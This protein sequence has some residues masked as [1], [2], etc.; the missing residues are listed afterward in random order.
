MKAENRSFVP[1]LG[2]VSVAGTDRTV[3]AVSD[4]PRQRSLRLV[5]LKASMDFAIRK[6]APN[7]KLSC[8]VQKPMTAGSVPAGSVLLNETTALDK[9]PGG[10]PAAAKMSR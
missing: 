7:E 5:M 6:S 10:S 3:Q 1:A 9:S 4:T 2:I 8:S